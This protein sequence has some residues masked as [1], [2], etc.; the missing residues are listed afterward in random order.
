MSDG[1]R[2]EIAEREL[3]S[4]LTLLAVRNPRVLTYA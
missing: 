2:L 4:G 1:I 3:P